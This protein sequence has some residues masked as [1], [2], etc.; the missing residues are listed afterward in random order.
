MT[1][2]PASTIAVLVAMLWTL[3][4]DAQCSTC[5]PAQKT[6]WTLNAFG[7]RYSTTGFSTTD[8]QAIEAGMAYWNS[9]Y[10]GLFT[11]TTASS[12]DVLLEIDVTLSGTSIGAARDVTAANAGGVIRFNPDYLNSSSVSDFV[13]QVAA[14]EFGHAQGF[15]DL[16]G[17]DGQSIMDGNASTSGPFMSSLSS[18]DTAAV[19]SAPAPGGG[20]GGEGNPDNECVSHGCSP[21][22][23]DLNGDGIHT[24][25]TAW[26]VLVG[27]KR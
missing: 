22:V 9:A 1:P 3:S 5:T 13:R 27:C 20:S 23:L 19:T 21:I 15:D 16:S 17:C 11:V 4:A 7:V 26:P 6:G 14:H 12:A 25:S 2:R 24:T 10:P 18:C 8:K